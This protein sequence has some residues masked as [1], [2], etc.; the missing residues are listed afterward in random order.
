[1]SR[2]DPIERSRTRQVDVAGVRIGGGTTL[3]LDGVSA[4]E[5]TRFH[6]IGFHPDILDSRDLSSHVLDACEHF[7]T[8]GLRD[9]RVPFD[10]NHVNNCFR[11][12]E[13]VLTKH[14]AAAEKS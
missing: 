5:I 6:T 3:K 13:F 12:A 7:L 1:M 2:T 8:V 14:I 9:A 4:I 10:L 11:L